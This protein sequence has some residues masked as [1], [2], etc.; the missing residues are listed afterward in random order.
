[1]KFNSVACPQT[2][3]LAKVTN[4]DIIESLK[5]CIVNCEAILPPKVIFLTLR[6]EEFRNMTSEEELCANLKLINKVKANDHSRHYKALQ[7]RHVAK[8]ISLGNLVVQKAEVSNMTHSRGKLAL[9][10]GGPYSVV[11]VIRTRTY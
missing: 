4:K 3:E 1:M 8:D 7:P 2:N 5:K 6:M 11:E 9:N 10:C